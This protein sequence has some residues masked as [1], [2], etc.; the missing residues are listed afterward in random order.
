MSEES[1]LA[2]EGERPKAKDAEGGCR[3]L[4]DSADDRLEPDAAGG[5]ISRALP[6]NGVDSGKICKVVGA[7]RLE[8]GNAA[9]SASGS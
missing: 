3:P 6:D 9:E 7:S 8:A 5:R 4:A 2:L 1:R